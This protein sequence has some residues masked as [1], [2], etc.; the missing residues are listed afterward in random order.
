MTKIKPPKAEKSQVA[1]AIFQR[2]FCAYHGSRL[3]YAGIV[4]TPKTGIGERTRPG[5]VTGHG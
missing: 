5:T 1:T 3:D 2:V 4:L